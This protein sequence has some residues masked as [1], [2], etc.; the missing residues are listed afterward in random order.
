MKKMA[1]LSIIALTVF[2]CMQKGTTSNDSIPG[3]AARVATVNATLDSFNRAAA[4]ADFNSYFNFYTD[5][6]I[7]TGTD[8]TERWNK[9]EFM[10]FAKPYF[11]KGKAWNFTSLERHI[12]F[13][14]TSNY[15][16]FDELLNTQMKICRGSGVL[17]KKNDGWKVEQYIL[18]ATI[19]N[20]FMDSVVKLKAPIEDEM[21]QKMQSFK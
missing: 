8:A 18:S 6:S 5:N 19:P 12:Y 10:A 15:A 4:N 13:D 20:S 14:T 3:G 2:S 1:T 16:W 17:V 7:F 9:K 11:D 21:I